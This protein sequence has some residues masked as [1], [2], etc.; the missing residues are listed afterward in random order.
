MARKPHVF[1]DDNFVCD[2]YRRRP[3]TGLFQKTAIVNTLYALGRR[4]VRLDCTL[5][6]RLG[7]CEVTFEAALEHVLY[8]S[9]RRD[10]FSAVVLLGL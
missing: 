3:D 1:S 9:V 2:E 10:H 5:G 4:G 7:L 6:A 8:L